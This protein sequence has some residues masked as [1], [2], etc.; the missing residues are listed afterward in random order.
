ME[1]SNRINEMQYSAIRKLNPFALKAKEAGKKVYHLN[2]GAPDV[3]TPVEFF[4]AI[5]DFNQETLSYAPALGLE[6]LR[7]AMSN[8][9]DNKFSKDEIIITAGA[10]EALLFTLL[11][12]CNQEDE[13][14][15][16]DPYYSNYNSYL[17][18]AD[19][20]LSTF[21]TK[22]EDAFSFPSKEVIEKS[23]NSKTKA[24]LICNPANPTGAVLSK[25]EIETIIQIAKE[26]DLYIIAD[27]IYRD[28]I[29]DGQ[30]YISFADYEDASDRV[31]ILDSISKRFS[32][33]GARIG[34]I[35][36][37]NKDFMSAIAKVATARLAVSTLEQVG[38]TALYKMN[39]SYL[40]EVND[41]YRERRNLVYEMLSKI[42]G[43]KTY[44]SEGAFYTIVGLP[45]E[46][47]DDF[48]KWLLTDFNHENETV[49]IA[50]A[51]GFYN[52]EGRGKNEARIAFAISQEDIKRAINLLEIAL[53]EYNK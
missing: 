18:E 46:D 42:D 1:I 40:K 36:S 8:Y 43:V 6:D 5:K 48:A 15:T 49:M 16:A 17:K 53:K 27:E 10:S 19:V 30:E 38:T 45:V 39:N 4:D 33:C 13:I 26:K 32:A 7:V 24:L 25:E 21:P 28:F 12:C 44:K 14:V 37:K 23:I 20:S 47:A 34:A 50:P 11:T 35:M 2:I 51:S 9:Y 31:I 41:E 52:E 3:Y 22:R 29:Y